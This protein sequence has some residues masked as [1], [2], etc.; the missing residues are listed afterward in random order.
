ML[1]EGCVG[2][3]KMKGL[4]QS[5]GGFPAIDGQLDVQWLPVNTSQFNSVQFCF[6]SPFNNG[7]HHKTASLKYTDSGYKF[8]SFK[9]ELINVSLYKEEKLSEISSGRNL[10][11]NQ[12]QNGTHPHLCDTR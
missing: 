3:G 8:N 1:H 10:E 4:A 9:Q 2:V 12:N 6:Y 5:I 7:H 11:R